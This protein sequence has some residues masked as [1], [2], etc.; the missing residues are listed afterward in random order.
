[1]FSNSKELFDEL[2]EHGIE[3]HSRHKQ[4]LFALVPIVPGHTLPMC[5]VDLDTHALLNK[6][7]TS[8]LFKK[9]VRS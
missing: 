5:E 9:L 2:A 1:M 4:S 3:L 6:L 8:T 7:L